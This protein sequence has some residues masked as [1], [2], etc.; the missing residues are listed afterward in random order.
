MSV[1]RIVHE[2]QLEDPTPVIAYKPCGKKDE[3]YPLLKEENFF[4][5]LMT[6]FQADMF[7][8]FCTFGCVD[9][10]HKT[11]EYG[12]KLITLL[13]VDEFRK[14]RNKTNQEIQEIQIY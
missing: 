12:Y 8:K 6:E 1:D 2:L 5:V 9:S 11:N 3:K 7:A 13:V 14:G 10:T 4:I